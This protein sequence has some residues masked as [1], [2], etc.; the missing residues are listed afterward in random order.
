MGNA[1]GGVHEQP[2]RALEMRGDGFGPRP[3]QTSRGLRQFESFVQFL[4]E[5]VITVQHAGKAARPFRAGIEGGQTQE[6]RADFP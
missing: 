4:P 1:A 2:A 3:L 5:P 6:K